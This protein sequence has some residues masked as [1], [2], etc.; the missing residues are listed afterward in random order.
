MSF[1]A[2]EDVL[3][4]RLRLSKKKER[5]NRDLLCK[6]VIKLYLGISCKKKGKVSI[7]EVSKKGK[8]TKPIL[9]S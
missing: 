6:Q 7:F 8:K 5:K 1:L 2:S 9:C 4:L 3:C